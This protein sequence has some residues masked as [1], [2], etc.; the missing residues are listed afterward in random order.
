[1]VVEVVSVVVVF[2]TGGGFSPVSVELLPVPF[3]A[4]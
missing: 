1:M 3:S 2:S 4:K